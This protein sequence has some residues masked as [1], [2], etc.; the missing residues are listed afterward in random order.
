MMSLEKICPILC[1]IEFSVILNPIL[2]IHN[3]GMIQVA[4]L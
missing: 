4:R 1:D 2:H 3:D